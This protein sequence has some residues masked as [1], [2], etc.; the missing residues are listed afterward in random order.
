M[1]QALKHRCAHLK[2]RVASAEALLS[3]VL[4][5]LDDF[6]SMQDQAIAAAQL[7]YYASRVYTEVAEDALQ[8]HGGVG[9]AAEHV[10]HLFLKRA[11]LN[12]NL[13]RSFDWY[14][15]KAAQQL[16]AHGGE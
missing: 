7:K 6:S 10:C 15:R 9:M 13:G 14:E 5:G 12:Q 11:M 1:F 16:L 3:E 8:L 4:S 2:M